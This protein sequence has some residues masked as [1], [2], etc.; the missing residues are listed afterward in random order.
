VCAV[1]GVVDQVASPRDSCL[2][3]VPLLGA[4]CAYNATVRD[5]FTLCLWYFW[6]CEEQNGLSPG[7]KLA[8]FFA[9]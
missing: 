2:I 4:I 3:R 8:D 6:F 9:E 7:G 1:V 5:I